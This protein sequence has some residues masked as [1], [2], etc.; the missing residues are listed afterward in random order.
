MT[1]VNILLLLA[2]MASAIVCACA[3]QAKGVVSQWGSGT[4]A[5]TAAAAGF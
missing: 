4:T 1:R 5:V 2:V 3:S